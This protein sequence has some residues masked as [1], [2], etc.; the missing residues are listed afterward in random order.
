MGAFLLWHHQRPAPPQG[1]ES[2]LY[3]NGEPWQAVDQNH[4]ETPLPREGKLCLEFRLWSGLTD[5]EPPH[6]VEHKITSA[7]LALLDE[8][9][10]ASTI[11]FPACWRPTASC[12]MTAPTSPAF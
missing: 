7:A 5:Q 11:G 6:P 4:Q 1:F 2:L 8:T 9:P 3:V 10:T 12:P